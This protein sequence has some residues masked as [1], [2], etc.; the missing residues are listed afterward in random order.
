MLLNE[1]N[2]VSAMLPIVTVDN[3]SYYASDQTSP[4]V[5]AWLAFSFIKMFVFCSTWLIFQWTQHTDN[6]EGKSLFL[7]AFVIN[8]I[9]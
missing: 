4:Y 3:L 7:H 6:M 1:N 9:H 2:T 5:S 8:F